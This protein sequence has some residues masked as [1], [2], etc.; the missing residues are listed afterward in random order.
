MNIQVS[1][2]IVNYNTLNLTSNCISSIQKKVNSVRYEIIVVDN[3]SKDKSVDFIKENYPEVLLISSEINLGF[4]KANNLGATY[5]KGEYLFLLNSDTIIEQDPFSS[6]FNFINN[7]TIEKIGV[8]GTFLENSDNAYSK[9]GGLFYSAK[10]YL[11]LGICRNFGIKTKAEVNTKLDII[12]VDY[13]IGA[14]MFIKKQL[15]DKIH[16]FD[17]KIFMYFEDVE[18]C[19]RIYKIGYQSFILRAGKIKHFEKSSSSSQ[20]TRVYNIASLMYCLHKEM[21]K[22]TFIGFQI[23]YFLIKFPII[24]T[25]VHKIKDN[26]TYISTIFTYKKYLN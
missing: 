13:V 25:D 15:F 1:I 10:K 6:F 17:N 7:N 16:G 19:K 23:L 8:L 26:T 18:L 12:P 24:F 5:A 21:H 22:I 2:I 9:S 11:K 4:G 3:A 14:D 20:F